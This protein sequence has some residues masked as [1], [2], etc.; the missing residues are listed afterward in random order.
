MGTDATS[1]QAPPTAPATAP[2]V[3]DSP[4]PTPA[5]PAATPAADAPSAPSFPTPDGFEWDK[6]DGG[7][8][9]LPDPLRPWAD[10]FSK[11]YLR[12]AEAARAE[13]EEVR[14]TYEAL[15]VG[16]EDPRLAKAMQDLAA[17]Q[18]EIDRHQ[19]TA[20]QLEEKYQALER[21]HAEFQRQVNE[22]FEAQSVAAVERFK[23][24]NAWIFDGG[25]IQQAAVEA[26]DLG[27]SEEQ[28]P[29]LLKLPAEVQA[30]ANAIIKDFAGSADP[31]KNALRV[32]K[33]E[34]TPKVSPAASITDASARG[35]GTVV[36][37]HRVGG[38]S[39]QDD[40]GRAY[41]RLA[42]KFVR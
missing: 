2:V 32:A 13:A 10:G 17:R 21:Q 31:G 25:P 38:E 42:P 26:L 36:P 14:K 40:F 19:G 7:V 41:D 4:P 24:E 35:A 29:E 16:Q 20:K 27:F 11:H 28:L 39:W 30:R 23:A 1:I 15:L 37:L 6:W 5:E 34:A 18:A 3:V 9:H 33:A 12:T 22:H 8:D